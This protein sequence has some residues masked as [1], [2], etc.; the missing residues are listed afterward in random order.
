M[1]QAFQYRGKNISYRMIGKGN[2]VVLL[3]GFG[4]DSTI[5][6]HQ[7]DFLKDDCLL[8]VPDLPGSGLSELNE[9]LDSIDAFA[10]C[11]HALLQHQNIDQCIMLGHSMGGYITL[12]FAALFPSFL[13]K[14]GLIHSTA[15]ADSE[16]KKI[17]RR[18]G[19]DLMNE[20]GSYAFLKNTIPNLFAEKYKKNY[21]DKIEALIELSHQFSKD[22][23]I[24]YYN[25]MMLRQDKTTVLK[26]SKIPVLFIMGTD[27]IAVPI[28]DI[29]QQTI[30][31]DISYIHILQEVGHMGM[32]EATHQLN[33]RLLDFVIN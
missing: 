2:A 5:F 29:L 26:S 22:A 27:D 13:N 9:Q 16:E 25:I 8:I 18:K 12:S 1:Y 15:Y 28:D 23:L 31:P 17:N 32:W 3:H 4:E 33:R 11:I 24:Q 10:T 30:L 20:Y 7:I 19:I 21:P 6:N 14:F